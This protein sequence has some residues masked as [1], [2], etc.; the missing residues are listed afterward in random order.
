MGKA[1]SLLARLLSA[2]PCIP[3]GARSQCRSPCA[4]LHRAK[5]RDRP[6][7]MTTMKWGS[8]NKQKGKFS[9][10]ISWAIDEGRTFM[11]FHIRPNGMPC[12]KNNSGYGAP[13]S[14]PGHRV[15]I[16]DMIK[17]SVRTPRGEEPKL[18]YYSRLLTWTTSPHFVR[19]R[20]AKRHSGG[21]IFNL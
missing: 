6:Y 17:Q 10:H 20:R 13:T 7:S 21:K 5:G 9:L 12:P 19:F 11:V 8:N 2:R 15:Y 1:G 16:W 3:R 14:S 4:R 18:S